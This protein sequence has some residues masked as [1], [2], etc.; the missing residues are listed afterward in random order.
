MFTTTKKYKEVP[1]ECPINEGEESKIILDGEEIGTA[2]HLGDRV[3]ITIPLKN[4][5]TTTFQDKDL[6]KLKK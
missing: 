3:R 1:F 2:K 4:G 5:I 6:S